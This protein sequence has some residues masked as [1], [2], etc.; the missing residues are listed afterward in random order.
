MRDRVKYERF[1]LEMQVGQV[2][3]ISQTP[4]GRQVRFQ[5]ACDRLLAKKM[6]LL[7][8]E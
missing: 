2:A 3:G 5:K 4:P 6:E 1:L 8:Q 7:A